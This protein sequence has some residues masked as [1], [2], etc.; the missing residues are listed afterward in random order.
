MGIKDNLIKN[1]I[2]MCESLGKY[3]DECEMQYICIVNVGR[4]FDEERFE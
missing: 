4:D 3:C 2:K 1:Q